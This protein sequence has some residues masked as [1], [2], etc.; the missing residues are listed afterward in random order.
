MRTPREN[1]EQH[2]IFHRNDCKIFG[3][4]QLRGKFSSFNSAVFKWTETL[5]N[6]SPTNYKSDTSFL[7]MLSQEKILKTQIKSELI[8]FYAE[9]DPK[10]VC[11]HLDLWLSR[12]DHIQNKK[13]AIN[14][15]H[16]FRNEGLV[17]FPIK[18]FHRVMK[19]IM[20]LIKYYEQLE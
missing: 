8:N 18:K 16:M 2:I 4:E 6:T 9:T 17:Q 13:Q 12:I 20:N 10:N 3:I 11:G 15:Y 19:A 7:K 14:R 1:N 5:K